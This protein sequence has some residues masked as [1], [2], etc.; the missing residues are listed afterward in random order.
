MALAQT[1]PLVSKYVPFLVS[2][3]DHFW[4]I[5]SDGLHYSFIDPFVNPVSIK[6]G[7]ISTHASSRG[8]LARTNSLLVFNHITQSDSVT[9]AEIA[10]VTRDGK[11]SVDSLI[12]LRKK[13]H[14]NFITLGVEISAM[15]IWR[16]T[17]I[18]GGG[19][20]GVAVTKIKSEGAG[21]LGTDSLDFLGLPE[22]RDTSVSAFRCLNKKSCSVGGLDELGKIG[23]PDSVSSLAVDSSAPDS[24][25]LLIGTNKGLRRGLLGGKVFS[26]IT[27]PTEKPGTA[28]R[29]E[30]IVVSASHNILWVFSGSEYF[31]SGDHGLTFH[32]PPAVVGATTKPALLT[33]FNPG[34]EAIMD[35]DTSFINFNM[36]RPGLVLFRK[37]S[38]AI[39]AGEGDFGDAVFDFEN[40][41]SIMRGEGRLTT[42][43]ILR[44]G[45]VTAII[46]G[47][48]SKGIF[49]RKTGSGETA[50][51]L[52]INSLKRLQGSLEEVITFPTLFT[53]VSASGE[54]DYVHIGYRLKKEG[55]VT[56]T[57]YNY[58]MEKVKT[59]VRSARRKGGGSRSE[60]PLEDRWDGRDSGGRP[61][62]LGTYYILVE[63]DQGEKGWGKAIAVRGRNP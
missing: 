31:F 12:F 27:L 19:R 45:G 30:K 37:D 47:S 16:D 48:T 3:K 18:L 33:G 13:L 35:G 2:D 7:S 8:A 5:S 22:G 42:L 25:W 54:P 61:V 9:L 50:E 44:S 11:T 59:L 41:L 29:I 53:G 51:W 14:N 52:N 36:D 55:M 46:A 60:S 10:S 32:K 40:G 1:D 17:L 15:A 49:L 34:P 38:L 63:S 62:S 56:I 21:T 43:A 6:N 26:K 20:G 39:N 24:I 23:E 28:I 57:V 58:A 4:A